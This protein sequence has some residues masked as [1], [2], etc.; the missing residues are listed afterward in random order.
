MATRTN[1]GF[2]EPMLLLRAE[3]L[4][5]DPARWAYQLKFYGYRAVAFKAGGRVHLRARNDK[6]FNGSYPAVVKAL[7]AMPDETV[8]DGEVIA[9]DD[10]LTVPYG[11]L[12]RL[13][14][15]ADTTPLE[16]QILEHKFYAPGIGVVVERVLRGGQEVSRLVSFTPA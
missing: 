2:I 16:P 14:V 13:V 7:S 8:I 12:D 4:P 5:D 6:D 15:T 3:R 1:A 9:L 10:S 11:A